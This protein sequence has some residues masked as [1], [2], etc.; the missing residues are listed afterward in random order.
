MGEIAGSGAP[1]RLDSGLPVPADP[2]LP[3]LAAVLDGRRMAAWL[4]ERLGSAQVEAEPRYLRYKRASKATV[5][6]DLAVDGRHT[7]AVVS[8]KVGNVRREL[9]RP[10]AALIAR[11]AQRRCLSPE[12]FQFLKEPGALVEWY[13]ARASMPGLAFDAER[14]AGMLEAAGRPAGSGDPVLVSYKPERRAVQRW[15]SVY[16]KSYIDPGE[17][18]RAA[19][20]A[21]R[22]AEVSGIGSPAPEVR[23]D[24]DRLLAFPEVQTR[25]GRIDPAELGAVLARLHASAPG[26]GLRQ[27]H[28][29][30]QLEAAR[31]TAA[32]VAWLLPE[33]EPAL[34]SV[35]RR[36]STT[37]PDGERLVVSH[38]DLHLGQ[39]LAAPGGPVLID[40]DHMCLAA[41]AMD[42][43]LLAA[44]LVQGDRD[45]LQRAEETLDELV[46]G[47]GR[48]P[49]D[50]AW[51]LAVS[52][53]GRA[54]FPLRELRIDWPERIRQMVAHAGQIVGSDRFLRAG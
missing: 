15:G 1:V 45:D 33:L 8:I 10:E 39:A 20:A 21:Q 6:Y 23:D 32:H 26:P 53:L 19:D 51:H 2:A 30:E 12:P 13:P 46:G 14:L 37:P 34:E 24:E 3:S 44:H 25:P 38:G 22:S 16:V 54:G 4:A 52:I 35:L 31:S 50:L 27:S 49:P 17:Y 47:Y 43:G 41:P 18:R 48:R 28:P 29:G 7:T 5:L 40:F 9:R 42:I 36:L 11:R